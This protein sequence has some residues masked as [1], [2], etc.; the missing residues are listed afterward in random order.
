M[1]M[2]TANSVMTAILSMT[3]MLAWPAWADNDDL[4]NYYYIGG[5]DDGSSTLYI[6]NDN[7]GVFPRS[8]EGWPVVA[9]MT[10]YTGPAVSGGVFAQRRVVLFKCDQATMGLYS[11]IN[12][13]RTA[14]IL[15]N[16]SVDYADSEFKPIYMGKQYGLAYRVA[17]GT[18]DAN[19]LP[20]TGPISVS[21]LIENNV[22]RYD[23]I[24][25]APWA[26]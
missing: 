25:G 1:K 7:N 13:F 26:Y 22:M 3:T 11:Y 23:V 6:E 17:C 21:K 19:T 2:R 16:G 15:G 9:F 18:P 20:V 12:Y 10:V 5:T 14:V 8:D 4:L 24:A